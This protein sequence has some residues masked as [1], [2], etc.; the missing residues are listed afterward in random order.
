MYTVLYTGWPPSYPGH[1][2]VL[3][4]QRYTQTIQNYTV[5]SIYI[6]VLYTVLYTDAGHLAI[7]ATIMLLPAQR[8][9]AVGAPI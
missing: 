2:H 7:L 3:P 6:C 9:P 4:A 8:D 1:I 5:H